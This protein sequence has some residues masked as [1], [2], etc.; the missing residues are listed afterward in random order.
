VSAA[1]VLVVDDD[2][3]QRDVVADALSHE[4]YDVATASSGAEAIAAVRA[5]RPDLL[6]LDLLLPDTDGGTVLAQ[7]REDPALAGVR[8]IVTTG[9]RGPHVRRLL[10]ADAALFKPFELRELLTAV[11]AALSRQPQA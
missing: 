4:G 11:A 2:A 5:R 10:D 8:V 7:V 9:M 3:L 1:H 6:V